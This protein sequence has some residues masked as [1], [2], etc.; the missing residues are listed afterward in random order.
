VLRELEKFASTGVTA[1]EVSFLKSAVGLR[2]ARLF[3]TPAQKAG[4]IQRI[5]EYDLPADYVDFQNKILAGITKAEIDQLSA[6][7]IKTRNVNI[8]L[9]GDKAG[10]LPGLQKMGYEIV[11]LDVNGE[12]ITPVGVR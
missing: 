9:V 6:K 12:R 4:F 1:E 10:M 8:L 11:E 2:D 3:E 5:L 7:W